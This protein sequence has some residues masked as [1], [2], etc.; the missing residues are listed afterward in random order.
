MVPYNLFRSWK[1]E[2]D[3]VGVK[4]EENNNYTFTIYHFSYIH[5]IS[6]N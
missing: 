3:C 5:I 6:I 4:C 2:V 1:N